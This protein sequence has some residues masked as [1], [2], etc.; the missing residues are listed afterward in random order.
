NKGRVVRYFLFNT[1]FVDE[2]SYQHVV[3]ISRLK[4]FLRCNNRANVT[5]VFYNTMIYICHLI[6][7]Y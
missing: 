7:M 4:N 6:C 2:V 3:F 5:C 1:Q